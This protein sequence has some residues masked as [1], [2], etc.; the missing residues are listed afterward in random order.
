MD[1]NKINTAEY[2]SDILKYIYFF[3]K[4]IIE[5]IVNSE[6]Y[7]TEKE[8]YYLVIVQK[9]LF[10]LEG[11]NIFIRAFYSHPEYHIPLF[12]NF[13]AIINDIIT[14]ECLF[15]KSKLDP[16]FDEKY[17]IKTIYSDHLKYKL[18]K[19]NLFLEKNINN[20]SEAYVKKA[21]V[22]IAPQL[23]DEK[24]DLVYNE[25]FNTNKIMK[26]IFSNPNQNNPKYDILKISYNLYDTFSKFEHFGIFTNKLLFRGL[27]MKE[28]ESSL[29]KYLINSIKI[30]ILALNNYI[31]TWDELNI[32]HKKIN[33]LSQKIFLHHKD[34]Y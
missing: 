28:N 23:F 14:T 4:N 31:K 33:N 3:K 16:N 22:N 25:E 29:I 30:I 2:S 1:N 24:G 20:H 21:L 8:S 11:S 19:T 9:I 32:D 6:K 27:N 26:E 18:S 12:I 10:T 34:N 13:R 7:K 5:R 17:W 15:Y